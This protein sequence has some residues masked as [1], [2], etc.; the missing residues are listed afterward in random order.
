MYYTFRSFIR[1]QLEYN[2]SVNLLPKSSRLESCTRFCSVH[3]T[4]DTIQHTK[5]S[6]YTYTRTCRNVRIPRTTEKPIE[7]SIDRSVLTRDCA[8]SDASAMLRHRTGTRVYT[9]HMYHI[10]YRICA[11]PYLRMSGS[12]VRNF[13]AITFGNSCFLCA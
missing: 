5:C 1:R 13:R 9:N 7:R 11:L 8:C 6:D 2:V 4:Y 10:T 3:W 12:V